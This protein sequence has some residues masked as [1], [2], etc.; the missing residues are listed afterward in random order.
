MCA[1]EEEDTCVQAPKTRTSRE[2][3]TPLSNHLG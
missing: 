2:H 1:Y 3:P